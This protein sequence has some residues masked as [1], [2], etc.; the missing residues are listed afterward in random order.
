MRL[1]VV[2]YSTNGPSSGGE[3]TV[4]LPQFPVSNPTPSRPVF[5]HKNKPQM[6]AVRGTRVSGADQSWL[7]VWYPGVRLVF[8][9]GDRRG[10]RVVPHTGMTGLRTSGGST[11]S[12][13]LGKAMI[14]E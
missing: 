2:M 1:F 3:L 9:A 6:S 10:I 5:I 13:Y 12:A 11:V 4:T 8:K 14:P 7:P